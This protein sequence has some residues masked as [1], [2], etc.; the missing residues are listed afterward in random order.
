MKAWK[1]F[2]Q[3]SF[4]LRRTINNEQHEDTINSYEIDSKN[5]FCFK[6]FIQQ[7]NKQKSNRK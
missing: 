4:C 5:E 1:K 6:K 2:G 3:K 7:T